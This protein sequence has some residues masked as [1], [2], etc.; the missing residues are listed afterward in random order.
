VIQSENFQNSVIGSN[1]NKVSIEKK[2]DKTVIFKLNEPN[3]YFLSNM[4]IG[5]LPYHILKNIPVQN[6]INADFNKKPI[7]TGPFKFKSYNTIS[8]GVKVILKRFDDYYGKKP[9]IDEIDFLVYQN[10][11]T[12]IKN[13]SK[14]NA[15]PKVSSD[16][17]NSLRNNETIKMI[18]YE[19]PQYTALFLNTKYEYLKDKETRMA[20]LKAI[21]INELADML[22]DRKPV[23]IGIFET[24]FNENLFRYD[25]AKSQSL[26]ESKDYKIRNKN[27]KYRKNKQGAELIVPIIFLRYPA[28][29]MMAEEMTK[30]ANYIS[31]KWEEIGVKTEIDFLPQ[32]Q[33]NEAVKN[34]DYGAIVAGESFSYDMDLFSFWHST[35]AASS[36]NTSGGLNFSNYANYSV[37]KLIEDVKTLFDK[38]KRIERLAQIVNYFREDAPVLFLYRPVYYYATYSRFKPDKIKNFVYSADRFN[39]IAEWGTQP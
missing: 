23:G 3:A 33:F 31:K 2:D 1:F 14:F 19:L 6:I 5:I 32:D 4:T 37:D 15:I 7:G 8:D 30:I 20:L 21:N 25:I 29:S 34:N 13:L 27:D 22:V 9:T 28:K 38:N 11:D 17:A 26:L 36:K 16:F 39:N 12:L 18:S 10:S 35:Q 24:E